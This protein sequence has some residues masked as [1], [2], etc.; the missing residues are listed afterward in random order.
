MIR[1][2][3]PRARLVLAGDDDRMTEGNPGRTKATEA[4]K[5]EGADVVFPE[6]PT[7]ADGSDWNDL[8]KLAGLAAVT[9]ALADDVGPGPRLSDWHACEVFTGEPPPRQWL[10][11]GVF[12]AGKPALLAAAGG[13]GKSFLLLDL[14]RAVAGRALNC[15]LGMLAR[16]GAAVY[17]T[18]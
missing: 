13:I 12:P 10:V 18:A 4:A 8:A 16:H 5:A 15:S 1:E 7:G 17:L 3:F 2:R 9:Q 14:A 6:F 11:S